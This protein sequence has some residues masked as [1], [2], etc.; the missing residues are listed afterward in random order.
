MPFM[1]CGVRLPIYHVMYLMLY[2]VRLPIYHLMYFMLS[3]VVG[4]LL[5]MD[6]HTFCAF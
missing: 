1:L 2:G 4:V 6:F 3:K 5:K